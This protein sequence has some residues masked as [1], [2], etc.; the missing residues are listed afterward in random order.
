M[1]RSLSL[2]LLIGAGAISGLMPETEPGTHL[3][4]LAGLSCTLAICFAY[5][6]SRLQCPNLEDARA[7]LEYA[8][9]QRPLTT[10]YDRPFSSSH[11]LTPSLWQQHIYRMRD[12]ANSLQA[13]WPAPPMADH[14][15]YAFRFIPILALS[16]AVWTAREAPLER[17]K[18]TL[19]PDL[20]A[21]FLGDIWI[22]PP[23]YL[24]IPPQHY[25]ITDPMPP[26]QALAG[27]SVLTLIQ[28]SA[29]FDASLGANPITFQDMGN[30]SQRGHALIPA[31]APPSLAFTLKKSLWQTVHWPVTIVPD[32]PPTVALH[33]PS[34]KKST[35][36]QQ[37]KTTLPVH[38]LAQDDH[39]LT[40]VE[41]E[42]KL[43]P[44]ITSPLIS[45]TRRIPLRVS[46]Q[47]PNHLDTFY[48][49]DLT[50]HP[51]A[52]L[53]LHMRLVVRD[54]A[55]NEGVS[56]WQT[57]TLPERSFSHP[58]ATALVSVRKTLAL[59]M[60]SHEKL[61]ETLEHLS[62]SPHDFNNDLVAFLGM[63]I[64]AIR[65]FPPNA[66]QHPDDVAHLLWNLALRIED[67]ETSEAQNALDHARHD[68]KNSLNNPQQIGDSLRR[69]RH[70]LANFFQSMARRNTFPALNT[71]FKR[72]SNNGEAIKNVASPLLSMLDELE[73]LTRL[74]A[75]TDAKALAERIDHALR[76]LQNIHS[77]GN[78]Q[79]IHD[80]EAALSDFDTLLADQEHLLE[81]TFSADMRDPPGT[82]K[83]VSAHTLAA[84]QKKLHQKLLDIKRRLQKHMTMHAAPL[85]RAA[86][87]MNHAYTDLKNDLYKDSQQ[88][89]G[90]A[91][92]ALREAKDALFQTFAQHI[93]QSFGFLPLPQGGHTGPTNGFGIG[94]GQDRI[95]DAPERTKARDVLQ[96]LRRRA[97][98]EGR[99]AK[100]R[101]YLNKLMT[102]F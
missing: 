95:P 94:L 1:W 90:K 2:C 55:Q 38:I 97:L 8:H 83:I 15:P 17:L 86:T 57:V 20:S 31:H 85:D 53:S 98:E 21:S 89:Q 67:R 51:W 82:Q 46:T 28:S 40:D 84:R 64:A 73:E 76:K 12:I 75:T 59:G 5:D 88:A 68:L 33:L 58:V 91:L 25:T 102:F 50:D 41:I 77:S 13:R 72:F 14:D 19:F 6:F 79:H 29:S 56:P 10:L 65:L 54:G 92:D 52:G 36:Q 11:A 26:L 63:R 32:A 30:G 23:D 93:G 66:D 24:Q 45:A 34:Q 48:P 62:R 44:D 87:W 3:I 35:N 16:L 100:E 9:P 69:V 81:K 49:V 43:P 18:A 27:G 42:L 47:S 61:W 70:A 22:I 71:I 80:M 99:D 60:A 74:G 39:G 4:I 101:D 7:R 96:E 37:N 78:T